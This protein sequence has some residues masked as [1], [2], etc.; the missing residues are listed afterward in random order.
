MTE[1]TDPTSQDDPSEAPVEPAALAELRALLREEPVEDDELARERRIRAALDAAPRAG[2]APPGSLAAVPAPRRAGSARPVL[3]AAA[4]L[5]VLGIGGLFVV[6]IAS[7]GGGQDESASLDAG[8]SADASS[9]PDRAPA[10]ATAGAGA[11]AAAPTSTVV[12]AAPEAEAATSVV[13]LG[14]FADEAALRA[15]LDAAD[16]AARTSSAP[17]TDPQEVSCAAQQSA[18]GVVVLGVATVASERR[19]VVRPFDELVLLDPSTC[20]PA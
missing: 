3:V 20:A 17:A 2:E 16:G 13:D 14:V 19:V 1:P 10:E 11:D 7:S 4:V 12:P 15:E 18:Q 8:S 5:A 6:S 9:Q